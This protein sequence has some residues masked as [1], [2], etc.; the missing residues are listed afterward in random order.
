VIEIVPCTRRH[1][2]D[3][4]KNIREGDKNEILR[5][6]WCVRNAL[7]KCFNETL[8]PKTALIDGE[9][10]AC[11]GCSGTVLGMTGNPWLITAK[12]SEKY[13]VAFYSIYK[14]EVSEMLEKWPVLTNVVDASYAQAI[15][16]LEMVGFKVYDE[17]PIGKDGALFRRFEM[18]AE[19]A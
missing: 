19:Y 13:P 5:M 14:Q 18:R 17:E 16:I 11:W 6:G 7:W 15:K 1:L 12:I 4:R 3:L 2:L 10:A 9:T 8:E